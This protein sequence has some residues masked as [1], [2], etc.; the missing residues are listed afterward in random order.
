M[1][2]WHVL[3]AYKNWMVAAMIRVT[4]KDSITLNGLVRSEIM[5]QMAERDAWY[6]LGV[7]EVVNHIQLER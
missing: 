2:F 6:V 4:I 7:K 1:T 3:C 5:K